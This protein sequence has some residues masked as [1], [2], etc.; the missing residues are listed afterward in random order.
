MT[1]IRQLPCATGPLT[2]LES[3]TKVPG[4]QVINGQI[5]YLLNFFLSFWCL[6]NI[7]LLCSAW[8]FISSNAAI[9]S[10]LVV[11]SSNC[12]IYILQLVAPSQWWLHSKMSTLK[13]VA[14]ETGG[15]SASAHFMFM[16]TTIGFTEKLS[17]DFVPTE[18]VVLSCKTPLQQQ[19]CS[20]YLSVWHHSVGI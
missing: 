13:E 8:V 2:L 19:S 6:L 4:Q 12:S 18:H 15:C 11:W 5:V 17:A 3:F 10:L 20:E 1:H 9:S 16:W 14:T 7:L